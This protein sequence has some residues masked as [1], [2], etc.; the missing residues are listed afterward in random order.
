MTRVFNIYFPN[1]TLILALTETTLIFAALLAATYAAFGTRTAVVLEYGNGFFRI[2][3][4]SAVCLLCMYYYDLYDSPVLTNPREV[5][6]RLVQVLGTACLILALLYYTYPSL[7]L[8]RRTFLVGVLMVGLLLAGWRRL[9]FV[10]NRSARLA[11]QALLLGDGPLASSV[12]R[13]IGNHPELGL[14]LVGYLG[15]E[16]EG[17]NFGRLRHLGTPS[18]LRELVE[19]GGIN[20]IIVTMGDRRGNLPVETLLQLKS[21]GVLV[22]DGV[23]LYEAVT[24]KVPVDALR[25]SWLLFSPG[26][27]SS[28]RTLLYKRATSFVLSLVG[29]V[30]SLPL[31]AVIALAVWLDTGRPIIFRQKRLGKDSKAFTLYK[32]RSMRQDADADGPPRPVTENDD[33]VTRVGKWLR[34][35]R[36]DEIPQFYNILRGD[37]HFVG[38]RPFVPQQEE[39][40]RQQIPFYT[41]R[42]SVK[43]GAT[44]W[45]QIHRGYCASL[46]DNI[47]KLEYDLFYIKHQS[48]G[49]DLL[50]AFQT[51]KILLLGRGGQ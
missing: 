6:T 34:R 18:E 23:D 43:P 29:L 28:T 39:E 35:S 4:A 40:C 9:F 49:L 10:L 26:F 24:G 36:L 20:R 42:W 47:E 12:A 41:Q 2:A 15:P 46:A 22:Q 17:G 33:R 1:R 21:H 14:R 32:F 19:P 27:R 5:H 38:P 31:M 8:D 48:V 3:L 7:G 44:G 25:L 51:L 30:L 11:E 50:I 13:E 45:A 37:M 16:V